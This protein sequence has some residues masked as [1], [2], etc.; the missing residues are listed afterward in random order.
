MHICSLHQEP[1]S[2]IYSCL[3]KADKDK[4]DKLN[5]SEVKNFLR[6]INIEMDDTYADMLFQVTPAV[7]V[8]A[9]T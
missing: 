2:W 8:E 1:S 5:Q 4:D 7:T 9:I 6:M 3:R